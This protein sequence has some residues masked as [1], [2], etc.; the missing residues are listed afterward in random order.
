MLWEGHKLLFQGNAIVGQEVIL[1]SD[2]LFCNWWLQQRLDTVRINI[3]QQRHLCLFV[4]SKFCNEFIGINNLLFCSCKFNHL[5]TSCI[6]I[7]YFLLGTNYLLSVSM[8]LLSKPVSHDLGGTVTFTSLRR[9]PVSST[10]SPWGL[11]FA[12]FILR[13]RHCSVG[14]CDSNLFFFF[15][16]VWGAMNLKNKIPFSGERRHLNFGLS[17]PPTKDV[18]DS[19]ERAE[20]SVFV[21]IVMPFVVSI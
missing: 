11:F 3:P 7:L 9:W 13:D 21:V 12:L 8:F 2:H 19:L 15:Y 18:R 14:L 5:P 4:T 1:L 17:L 20:S 10:V 16:T 6:P